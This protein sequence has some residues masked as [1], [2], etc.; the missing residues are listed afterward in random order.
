MTKIETLR[1]AVIGELTCDDC[2]CQEG[3]HYCLLYG[4]TIK[5]MDIMR[6]DDLKEAHGKD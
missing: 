4:T 2:E 1:E 3:R 6:C 5:N